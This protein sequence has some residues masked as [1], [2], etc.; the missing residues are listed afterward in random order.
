MKHI[1]NKNILK[2]IIKYDMA[3]HFAAQTANK[4]TTSMKIVMSFHQKR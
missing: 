3:C 1:K 2:K 4:D